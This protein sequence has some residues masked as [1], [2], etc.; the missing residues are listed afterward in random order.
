M[1][2]YNPDEYDDDDF[3]I[4]RRPDED[5]PPGGDFPGSGGPNHNRHYEDNENMHPNKIHVHF[6]PYEK[7]NENKG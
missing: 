7:R 6:N 1:P 4:Y 2:Y 5:D 3:D